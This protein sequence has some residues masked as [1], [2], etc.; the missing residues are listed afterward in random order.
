MKRIVRL[1]AFM[2]ISLLVILIGLNLG[3]AWMMVSAMTHP[4]CQTPKTPD[5]FPAY[6]EH[7]LTTEDGISIRTWYYPSKNSAAIITFGGMNGSLGNRLPPVDF[8]IH[9][10]YGVLQ[11]DSRACAQPS[12]PVTQGHDELYDAEAALG[13]LLSRPE[14]DPQ[15]I[16]V[17]G[18][19]MGGATALRVMA[20]HPE[21]R[22]AVRD[23][24]F[25]NLGK[26]LSP[27]DSQSIPE[28]I[29]QSTITILYKFRSGIDPWKVDPIADLQ[30]ISPKPVLLIYGEHEADQGWEQ[31][32]SAGEN[33]ELWIVP[34]GSH[35]RNFQVEP[36]AYSQRVRSF[37]DNVLLGK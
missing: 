23:G 33:V 17:T 31:Y 8:L 20:R 16:G 1:L 2:L 19:S 27:Q 28:Q 12:A 26:L 7:W 3:L 36:E 5:N 30:R 15:R 11:I 24:G 35:G 34:G 13:F 9:D 32:D 25:S 29:L 37:F 10:G 14:I 22:V 6:E 4:F 21:I 18:F